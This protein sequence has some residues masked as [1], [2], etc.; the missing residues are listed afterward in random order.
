[1]KKF[2]FATSLQHGDFH[3][4]N[5]KAVGNDVL[6]MPED[7]KT[8]YPILTAVNGYVSQSEEFE[9]IAIVTN[10]EATMRNHE[11]FK[12]ELYSICQKKKIVC[13]ALHE[14]I[15]PDDERATVQLDTFQKL[16][17]LIADEDELF[18]CLTYGSKPLST[19]I[20]VAVQY[21]YRIL[22]NVSIRCFVYGKVYWPASAGKA[23]VI[24]M[25]ALVQLD[26]I[27]RTLADRH[28]SNPKGIIKSILSL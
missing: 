12:E 4:F 23:D 20:Q 8:H 28:V 15:V 18:A 16:I 24:D 26:E 3:A 22:R 5:Y 9:V 14:I 2:I 25:T 17:D 21:A 7:E 6:Q 13:N 10:T 1:M 19:T 11:I 27:I